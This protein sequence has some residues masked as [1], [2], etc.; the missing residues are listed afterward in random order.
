M[1]IDIG[2]IKQEQIK[3]EIERLLKVKVPENLSDLERMWYLIDLVWD[4]MECEKDGKLDW[5]KVKDFYKHPVWILN[6]LFIEQDEISMKYRQAIVN[7]LLDRGITKILDY[8]GGF[9][10]LGRLIA[11]KCSSCVVDIYEPYPSDLAME[12]SKPYSN[13]RFVS[14]LDEKYSYYDCVISLDVLEHLDDPIETLI[15]MKKLVRDDGFLLIG[16]NFYPVIKCHL[17]KNFHFRYTFDL[18]SRVIGLRVIGRLDTSYIKIYRNTSVV[19]EGRIAWARL[20]E[21]ISILVFP[22]LEN[23]ARPIYRSIK[24][25]IRKALTSG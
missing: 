11:S 2:E 23:V 4:E 22:L 15:H 7:W 18:V 3:K 17:K 16:N 10:T 12:K 19:P 6:G 20:I 25:I 14:N 13:L 1:K 8:G 9:G 21:K 5:K 24:L